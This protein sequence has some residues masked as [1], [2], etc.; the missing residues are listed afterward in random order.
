MLTE[1]IKLTNENVTLTTY[2]LDSSPEMEHMSKKPAVLICP[3]GGYHFCSDRE[4]EPIAAA[5]LAMG[6]HAFVL[7]Y[8]LK[9]NAVFPKPLNDAEEALEYIRDNAERYNVIPDKIAVCGFSAGGHLAAAL[10]TMG[11]VRP[12]AMIL[13]YACI[14]KYICQDTKVLAKNVPVI[15]TAVDSS[16]PPTFIFATCS[17]TCVNIE[18]SVTMMAALTRE[19]VPFESHIFS[20]GPHGLATS[21]LV[22]SPKGSQ[23]DNGD[24]AKWLELCRSWLYRLFFD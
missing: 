17:D 2:V 9:E 12:N 13:C 4:A 5:F 19:G 18:N 15:D 23:G 8:S 10:G 22:T 24:C 6:L 7:R 20:E 21:S 1:K 3:G 16:T 14:T 11:R